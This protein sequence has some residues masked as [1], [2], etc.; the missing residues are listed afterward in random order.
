MVTDEQGEGT[1][2]SDYSELELP[3][4]PEWI[5]QGIM[6]MLDQKDK[7]MFFSTIRKNKITD[8]RMHVSHMFVSGIEA[9]LNDTVRM[10]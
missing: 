1:E 2:A 6:Q 3:W 5:S 4:G 7:A 9:V 8:T 10:G